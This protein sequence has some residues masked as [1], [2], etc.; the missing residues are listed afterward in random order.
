MSGCKKGFST[1]GWL[2]LDLRINSILL[3][4][5]IMTADVCFKKCTVP[6]KILDHCNWPREIMMVPLKYMV[7]SAPLETMRLNRNI[8]QIYCICAIY[9]YKCSSKKYSIHIS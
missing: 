3:K 8:Y 2:H 9:G 6:L 5:G 4:K 1:N 7:A